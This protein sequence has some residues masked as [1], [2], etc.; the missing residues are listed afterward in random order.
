MS[1]NRLPHKPR[2]LVA[3]LITLAC[4][5]CA[6]YIQAQED[7]ARTRY[8]E[9]KIAARGQYEDF[10]KKANERYAEFLSMAWKRFNGYPAIPKPKDEEIP[11]V[12]IPDEERDSV[13][14]NIDLVVIEAK[15]PEEPEPEPQ[16]V[17]V[18]P[19]REESE[20]VGRVV[21]FRFFGTD[22]GIRLSDNL[23]LLSDKTF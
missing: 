6:I 1:N 10:R 5:I 8:E 13:I 14:G 4:H 16:P 20:A 21:N 15:I 12:V 23:L 18:N 2:T 11:P 9:F 22:R 3:L 19:I 7:D 17:P